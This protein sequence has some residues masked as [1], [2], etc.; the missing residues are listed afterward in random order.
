MPSQVTHTELLAVEVKLQRE[1]DKLG[2][3]VDD[4]EERLDDVVNRLDGE[5]GEV[6]K[7]I[8]ELALQLQDRPGLAEGGQPTQ[9]TPDTRSGVLGWVLGLQ[10]W[11]R[12]VGVLVVL[13]VAQLAPGV[14][15]WVMGWGG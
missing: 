7:A 8:G 5:K 14:R 10:W 11:E 15:G 2:G 3:R 1:L 12:M 9:E 6:L 4:V 13:E